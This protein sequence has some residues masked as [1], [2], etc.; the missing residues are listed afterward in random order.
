MLQVSVAGA[1]IVATHA[2]PPVTLP[3]AT[4]RD[5]DVSVPSPSYR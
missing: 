3:T 4:L 1:G 5:F 2:V